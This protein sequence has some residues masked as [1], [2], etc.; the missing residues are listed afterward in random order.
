MKLIPPVTTP[1][2]KKYY[3]RAEVFR[4][5]MTASMTVLG[6]IGG[7]IIKRANQIIDYQLIIIAQQKEDHT[8]TNDHAILIKSNVKRITDLE[9]QGNQLVYQVKENSDAIIRLEDYSFDR[10]M[11]Q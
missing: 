1:P 8:I 6:V 5:V 3:I 10:T 2:S 7:V 11:G 4:I 9:N